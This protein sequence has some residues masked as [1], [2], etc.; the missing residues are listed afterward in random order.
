[1][2]V[3]VHRII[4][5]V[6]RLNRQNRRFTAVNSV[7]WEP[8]TAP[9][10]P[11][12]TAK[13]ASVFTAWEEGNY[14]ECEWFQDCK[15]WR[16]NEDEYM[17]KKGER[18]KWKSHHFIYW[19]RVHIHLL[20]VPSRIAL[21]LEQK[22]NLIRKSER[23][24]SYRYVSTSQVSLSSISNILKQKAEYV[25]DYECNHTITLQL[26]RKKSISDFRLKFN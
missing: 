11:R 4:L 10:R 18:K 15:R 19:I 14:R 12:F 21:T 3:P 22:V 24:S 1:M 9:V 2:S 25:I 20:N 26:F 8:V 5:A 13:N 23:G 16:W 7:M 6:N 17:R